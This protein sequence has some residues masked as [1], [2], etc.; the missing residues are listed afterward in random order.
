[1][2]TFGATAFSALFES[3]PAI[4]AASS[5]AV[6]ARMARARAKSGSKS[7]KP[8]IKADRAYAA[9]AGETGGIVFARTLKQAR[10]IGARKYTDG[11]VEHIVCI[12]AKWADWCA[13]SGIVHA[14]DM[15]ERGWKFEC[16]GCDNEISPEWLAESELATIDVIGTQDG[17]VF[18]CAACKS[19]FESAFTS[20]ECQ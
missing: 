7:A 1:M 8:A 3:S 6:T 13:P 17:D 20:G 18:C 12:R 16:R 5:G 10:Y 15:I 2:D 9:L 19:R 11:V 14:S 4:G